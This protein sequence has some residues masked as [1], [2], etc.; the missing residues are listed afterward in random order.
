MTDGIFTDVMASFVSAERS[1][2]EVN[3]VSAQLRIWTDDW[4]NCVDLLC[5]ILSSSM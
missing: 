2:T 3:V 4:M 5:H 1:G